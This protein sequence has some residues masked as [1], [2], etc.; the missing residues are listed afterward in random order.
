M[1][2]TPV[3]AAHGCSRGPNSSLHASVTVFLT[4][5]LWHL[6]FR[7]PGQCMMRHC[8]RVHVYQVWCG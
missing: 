6:T 7:P 1:Q 3:A 2:P 8:H 5:W 4:M